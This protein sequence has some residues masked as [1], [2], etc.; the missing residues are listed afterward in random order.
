MSLFTGGIALAAGLAGA[1]AGAAGSIYAANKNSG[2]AE[3]GADLQAKAAQDALDF[4]KA[5]KAKQETAYAP[6]GALGQ[7]AAGML[8]GLARQ[9]PTTGPPAPFTT[10]P[11]A[12]APMPQGAPLSQMGAPQPPLSQPFGGGMSQTGQM[13]LL[14]APDGS[15]K[16]VPQAQ[17]AAYIAKGAR[18]VG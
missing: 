7:Q 14:E 9:A 3:H 15:R 5:Q 1:G 8:P 6:F 4:T 12:T 13:V 16:S 2:A 18:Q 17:A 10:Q 11:R